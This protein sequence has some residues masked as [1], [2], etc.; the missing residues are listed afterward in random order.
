MTD[1]NSKPE[2]Q[3]T[4]LFPLADRLRPTR[5]EDVFGQSHLTARGMALAH[6]VERRRLSSA[7]LWGPPGSGKTTLSRILASSLGYHSLEF[8]ATIAKIA[9]IR[10]VM[11]EAEA[12]RHQLGQPIVVFVDEIHHFNKHMQDAFLPFVE[13]GDIILLGTT[14]ENPAFKLNRAL[15]SRMQILE[16]NPLQDKDLE[17]ILTRA[18]QILV[19]NKISFPQLSDRAHS[20]LLRYSAGDARRL[21]NGLEMITRVSTETDAVFSAEALAS[22]L[23]RS[24]RGYDRTGDDRYQLISA[25]HK[26]V[27]NSDMD[28]SLYW[29]SRMVSG[30]E[31]PLFLLRRMIRIAGEDIGLADPQALRICLDARKAYDTLGSPEGDIFLT[32]ATVYLASA[33]KSNALYQTEKRMKKIVEKYPREPVPLRLINPSHFLASQKGAGREY[34]YAHDYDEKTTPMTTLPDSIRES[35]F[36]I[37]GKLGFERTIQERLSFWKKNKKAMRNK[38][39]S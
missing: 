5:I 21:L 10:T 7:I 23:Q 35:L 2:N 1:T 39:K 22:I 13:K 17:Q 24:S 11:Q 8:S 28:A 33:P 14:T 19:Q 38:K 26:S 4:P 12:A 27:R 29:L 37:P 9:E 15:I 3:S 20:L 18:K 31:D 32:M 36:Y 25:F 34:L 6:M 16:L 30:G